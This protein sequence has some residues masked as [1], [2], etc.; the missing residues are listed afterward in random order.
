M[1]KIVSVVMIAT[2]FVFS[3]CSND[4]LTPPSDNG[5]KTGMTLKATVAGQE[6]TRATMGGEGESSTDWAFAFDGTDKVSVTNNTINSYY[7]FANSTENFV[8]ADAKTTAEAADWYAYFP[9]NDVSLANQDGTFAKVA[10]YYAMAGQ[11][12]AATTGVDGLNITMYPQV[13]ILRVVKVEKAKFGA[14]DINVRTADGKYIAGLAAKKDEAGFDIKTSDTKVTYLSQATPGVYYIAVPAGVKLSI[15]NGD[16][17]RNTT[18]DAGLTAG[19]YYTVLTG[20]IHGTEEA[21]IDGKSVQVGWIQMYPGGEKIA[22]QLTDNMTWDDAV[23][24][25]KDY[26]WGEK[27]RTPTKAEMDIFT[28]L[29]SGLGIVHKEQKVE[30]CT[31][32]GVS[33]FKFTGTTLGYTK[34]TLFVPVTLVNSSEKALQLWSATEYDKNNGYYFS[35]ADYGSIG[36]YGYFVYAGKGNTH[37][38]IP[39]INE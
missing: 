30:Y 1:K 10:N 14:C 38:V 35:L 37:K 5:V 33:G 4:D 32:D 7:T 39:I 23:K 11:T 9:S 15:Y 29:E 18:K 8:S 19:K 22:T 17:L 25:G 6:S 31:I 27:W 13:A 12:T 16:K 3:A 26:V 24:T 34:N 36:I 20:P 2:A 28:M 21:T